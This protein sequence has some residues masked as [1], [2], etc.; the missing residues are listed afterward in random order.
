[1][2]KI[3]L[4]APYFNDRERASADEVYQ[5]LKGLGIDVHFFAYDGLVL[6][7]DSP[8]KDREQAFRDNI[9]EMDSC[10]VVVAIVE[11]DPV[12][13]IDC[14]TVFDLTYAWT[15]GKTVYTY[16][17]QSP[18]KMNVMLAMASSGHASDTIELAEVLRGAGKIWG[19]RII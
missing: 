12:Y 4:A 7:P 13:G 3:Y 1:M 6:R 11:S 2:S 18:G 15:K 10:D 19:G 5:F 14:G 17:S 8:L 9:R 16:D